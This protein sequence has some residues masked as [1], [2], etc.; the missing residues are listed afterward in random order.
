MKLK[1][2]YLKIKISNWDVLEYLITKWSITKITS[3]KSHIFQF[4]W[5][6]CPVQNWYYLSP[7]HMFPRKKNVY[8]YTWDVLWISDFQVTSRFP[9]TPTHESQGKKLNFSYSDVDDVEIA[10]ARL[11]RAQEEE[12]MEE[13]RLNGSHTEVCFFKLFLCS[14]GAPGKPE[15]IFSWGVIVQSQV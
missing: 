13:A 4:V 2:L 10:R 14:P 3:I 15:L 12:R 1:R 7:F 6:K 11:R 5:K 9:H 8:L